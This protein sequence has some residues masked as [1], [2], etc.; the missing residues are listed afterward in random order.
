MKERHRNTLPIPRDRPCRP[1]ARQRLRLRLGLDVRSGCLGRYAILKL[2]S[3]GL[4]VLFCRTVLHLGE[5]AS[6]KLAAVRWSGWSRLYVRPPVVFGI[7][8][9][10]TRAAEQL[11]CPCRPRAPAAKGLGWGFMS[12]FRFILGQ[13]GLGRCSS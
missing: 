8:P 4:Q 11:Y 9:P 2:T 7:T 13:V 5:L 3:N 10:K 1:R 12:G 6:I